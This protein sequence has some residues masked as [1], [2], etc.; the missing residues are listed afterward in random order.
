MVVIS[1]RVIGRVSEH[2]LSN[3]IV[4]GQKIFVPPEKRNAAWL[5]FP[6]GSVAK[7]TVDKGIATSIVPPSEAELATFT[8]DELSGNT[9]TP[10]ATKTAP[11]TNPVKSPPSPPAVQPEADKEAHHEAPEASPKPGVEGTIISVMIGGTLNLGNYNNVK[12]EVTA[13]SAEAARTAFQ[14]EISGTVEMMRS[15]IKPLGA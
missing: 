12:M 11:I 8:R 15:I 14:Q 7:V 10:A 2:D 3:I 4:G 6:A 5:N 9:K 13:T 1:G